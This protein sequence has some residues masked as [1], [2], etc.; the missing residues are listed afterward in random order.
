MKKFWKK[1]MWRRSRKCYFQSRGGQRFF[2]TFDDDFVHL[3][4]EVVVYHFFQIF[5]KSFFASV[6]RS[7]LNVL[8]GFQSFNDFF[9]MNSNILIWCVNIVGFCLKESRQQKLWIFY[10]FFEGGLFLKIKSK[11]SV[12]ASSLKNTASKSMA[13]FH[14]FT[15]RDSNRNP[16]PS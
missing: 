2:Y 13:N 8:L 10:D 16:N 11:F 9:R 14:N 4:N 6:F 7:F 5:L 3:L 15:F 1:G 12:R